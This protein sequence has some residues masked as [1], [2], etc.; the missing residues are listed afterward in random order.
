MSGWLVQV[1]KGLLSP[2]RQRCCEFRVFSPVKLI[3]R[4]THF[5]AREPS[6]DPAGV[7]SAAFILSS[8]I[9]GAT[10]WLESEAH[11]GKFP[12]SHQFLLPVSA[13]LE[14][15]ET[16]HKRFEDGRG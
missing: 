16:Q 14:E 6:S 9:R 10:W 5:K 4:K 13:M 15:V 8:G 7:D 12:P 2:R 11:P 3:L 1:Q